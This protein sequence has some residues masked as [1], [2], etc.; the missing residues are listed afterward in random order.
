[1]IGQSLQLLVDSQES[2]VVADFGV[3]YLCEWF[4]C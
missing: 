4:N 3:V 1:M 2:L